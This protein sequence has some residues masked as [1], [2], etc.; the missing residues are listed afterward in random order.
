MLLIFASI[1][2]NE[3]DI[4]LYG[5]PEVDS[6]L[7]EAVVKAKMQVGLAKRNPIKSECWVSLHLTQPTFYDSLRREKELFYLLRHSLPQDN[8]ISIQ[9]AGSLYA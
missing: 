3:L 1:I 6:H 4:V 7:P 9:V 8:P 2:T 5:T